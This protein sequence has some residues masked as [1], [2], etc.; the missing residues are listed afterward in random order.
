MSHNEEQLEKYFIDNLVKLGWKFIPGNLLPR[1]DFDDPLIMS[2]LLDAIRRFNKNKNITEEDVQFVIN[3]LKL[4]PSGVTGAK[5]ILQFFKN[6]I[7][8]KYEKDKIVKYTSLFNYEK[9]EENKFIVSSQISNRGSSLIRNDIILYI[10]GIPLVN[11]ELKDPTNPAENWESAYNQ[12]KYYEP[13]FLELYKYIQIGVAVESSARYFPIVPWQE[14]TNT[15]IWRHK[16]NNGNKLDETDSIIQMLAPATL[17]QIINDFLFVR[18]ERGETTKVIVRYMQ[19]EAV[20]KIFRRVEKYF[21]NESDKNRGLI[22]HWQG[23]GKTFEIIFSANKLFRYSKLG[24]PS[25]YIILD[26]DDLQTQ[27]SDEYNALDIKG[28]TIISSIQKLKEN[29]ASD[30]YRGQRGIFIVLIHKFNPNEFFELVDQ[31]N[32]Q[33]GETI[34]D[35][36]NVICFIDEGHRSQSGL[37][38]SQMKDIF[39]NAFFFA[40]TGTPIVRKSINTY[41]EFCYPPEEKYLDKYFITESIED[42]YTKRILHEPRLDKL[43]LNKENLEYFLNAGEDEIPE[44]MRDEVKEEVSS[45]LDTIRVFHE[46]PSRIEEI[47]KDIS[48]HFIENVDGQYK[49]MIVA[50]S[51]LACVRY[52][53]AIDKFLPYEYSQVII[54]VDMIKDRSAERKEIFD[55]VQNLEN[56]NHGKEYDAIKK[57]VINN[58]KDEEL[59]KILIVTDMLLT[60]FDAPVLQTMYL[61]KPLKEQRL[62]Q[63]IARTNRPY[64]EKEAGLIID[65]VG[66]FKRIEKAFEFYERED[67]ANSVFDKTKLEEEFQDT[68][69]LLRNIFEKVNRE[70]DKETLTQAIKIITAD[71]ETEKSFTQLYRY[72]R[73]LF[74]LLGSNKIKLNNLNEYKWQTA[75][76]S[77]YYKIVQKDEKVEQQV[78]KFYKKTIDLI[79]KETEVEKIYQLPLQNSID[80]EFIKGISDSAASKE[81]KASNFVFTLNKFILVDQHKNRVYESLIERVEKLMKTW[82]ERAA[83][84]NSNVNDILEES[85][86]ILKDIDELKK[87]KAEYD[88]TDEEMSAWLTIKNQLQLEQDDIELIDDLRNLF[89]ELEEVRIPGWAKNAELKKII[90]KK[91]REFIFKIVKPKY[92]MD[93]DKINTLHKSIR[94]QMV[95]YESRD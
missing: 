70:Y 72:T 57:E 21:K 35:R 93:L 15:Y 91:I 54:S 71:K 87:K 76:Y 8:I 77:Y 67:I 73:R 20:N 3:E 36:R 32:A 25:I 95:S 53:N 80:E 38:A 18:E 92:P 65:Y 27:I 59:P 85:E 48:T 39:Q 42:E 89:D 37:L 24:S 22:W 29:I 40:F 47:A 61:D 16:D 43:H 74:E 45:R 55:Y 52:K 17:L 10:N 51:R 28:A 49:A 7:P 69:N 9:I 64:K 30:N 56:R 1:T 83:V 12:I 14:N 94:E 81:Y 23:S 41:S 63:A 86:N 26:R 66:I 78:K 60:G 79:H 46:M 31:V 82:R 44:N 88:L 13:I 4:V 19:Y 5:R 68:I 2:D 84:P 62:L 6:G 90:E 75:V 58:F 11:I 50:G 34:R 33:P